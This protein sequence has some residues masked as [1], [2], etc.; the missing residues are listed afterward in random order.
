[1]SGESNQGNQRID[2]SAEELLLLIG[3]R[4]LIK[5]K[6]GRM[7]AELQKQVS[8]MSEVITELRERLK[9]TEPRAKMNVVRTDG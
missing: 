7:I 8:E 1:M 3:E 9:E 6:Q 4:E 5:Y 2:T